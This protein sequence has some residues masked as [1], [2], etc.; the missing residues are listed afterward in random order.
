[1]GSKIILITHEFAPYRGGIATYCE[2]VA[3]AAV[4]LGYEIE[5]W[6]QGSSTGDERFPFPVRRLPGAGNLRPLSLFL[7]L[8]SLYFKTAI[9]K[10]ARVYLPSRG[11]QWVYM[12]L[13]RVLGWNPGKEIITTFHGTEIIRYAQNSWLRKTAT[14]FFSQSV[15]RLTTA[16][17]YSVGL[18]QEMG[19][20]ELASSALVAPC[21]LKED[22]RSNGFRNA[23]KEGTEK[24]EGFR[25]LTLARV[26]PRKGQLEVAKALALLDPV[27]RSQ[28]IY[29]IAGKGDEDYLNQVL[30]CCRQAGVRWE[31]LGEISDDKIEAVYQNCDLYVMSSRSL[32]GSVEGF[33]MTYLEAGFFRK[34]VVGY[35]TGGVSEAVLEGK[36]GYLV[37]E[38]DLQGLSKSI[39]KIL[40]N[41]L[42][43]RDMG[44]EGRKHSLSFSWKKTAQILFEKQVD[45]NV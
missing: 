24:S 38:G 15:H 23:A 21:A 18:L 12:N 9:L 44:E 35:R 40:Q 26:H 36:T 14:L 34:P 39:E 32:V 33:G 19:F 29:Q 20:G 17:A 45:L 43:A 41:R 11:S 37:D 31:V 42:L 22:F 27:F 3:R 6:T 2:E 13:Y 7:L 30:D 10:E 25:V 8:V 16:S 1:M 28:V 5:V 4:T